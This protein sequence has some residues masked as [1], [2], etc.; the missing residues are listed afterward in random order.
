MF[1]LYGQ[2]RKLGKEGNLHVYWYT[3][4]SLSLSLQ[5]LVADARPL[6]GKDQIRPLN[7]CV[8]LLPLALERLVLTLVSLAHSIHKSRNCHVRPPS[9]PSSLRPT[10]P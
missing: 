1:R 6:A 4:A 7:A 9:S 3:G 5:V 8:P 10:R 2:L